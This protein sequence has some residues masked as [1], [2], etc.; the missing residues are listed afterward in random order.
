MKRIKFDEKDYTRVVKSTR[1]YY[2]EYSQ[3]YVEFYEN[4][5]KR[6]SKFSD[7]IYRQGYETVAK[8]LLDIAEPEERVIDIGCGVGKWS[9]LL[10]EKGVEV[11]SMDNLPSML[12]KVTQRCKQDRIK[13]KV[14]PV[15]ADG[16]HLPFKERTFDGATLNWVL[17]HIPAAKNTIFVREIKRVT[18]HN[19]W[20]LISD[21]YWRGQKGGKEQIQ[22]REV[23]GKEHEVYKYY[24]EPEELKQL[25]QRTF[26][27]V[28]LLLPLHY[29]LICVARNAADP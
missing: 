9:A 11:V 18:K 6:Q 25:L 12:Q 10:A 28:E 17:A 13:S 23:N 8:V 3:K 4:W 24:Y 1:T 2:D 27:K 14:S 21:S 29:E 20:L 16:F 5:R 26:G 7:P 15:L 19:G 22:I